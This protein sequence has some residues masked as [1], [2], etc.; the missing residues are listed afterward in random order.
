MKNIIISKCHW[1]HL[2]CI[3]ISVWLVLLCWNQR[4]LL[5]AQLLCMLKMFLRRKEKLTKLHLYSWLFPYMEEKEAHVFKWF[6][7]P[8]FLVSFSISLNVGCLP[9]YR[10]RCAYFW[11]EISSSFLGDRTWKIS[12]YI[13]QD[14][15]GTNNHFIKFIF[16][17][18]KMK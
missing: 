1:A 10:K 5:C 3:C 6:L 16:F 18:S 7:I 14:Y 11:K 13:S 15:L 2:K 12:L 17:C 8:Q 9:L 4:S